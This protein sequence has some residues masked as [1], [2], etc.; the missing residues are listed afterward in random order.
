MPTILA[1]QEA[2]G[3]KSLEPRRRRLQ[4]VEILPLYSSLGHRARLHFKKQTWG[5]DETVDSKWP[6]YCLA[7]SR[8][9]TL[10]ILGLSSELALLETLPKG[11]QDGAI[12]RSRESPTSPR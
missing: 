11:E 10:A 6:A 1:T 12:Y 7:C 4:C 8:W 9:E 3:S 2:E 5:L